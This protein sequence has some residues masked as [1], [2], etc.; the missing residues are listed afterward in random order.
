HVTKCL[1]PRSSHLGLAGLCV[2]GI[3]RRH[4]CAARAS[5]CASPAEGIPKGDPHRCRLLLPRSPFCWAL[6]LRFWLG[7]FTARFPALSLLRLLHGPPGFGSSPRSSS[8]RSAP[9][10]RHHRYRGGSMAAT[11]RT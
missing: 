10:G 2:A 3:A 6:L 4:L 8:V 7:S 11:A 5:L 1:D 9:I